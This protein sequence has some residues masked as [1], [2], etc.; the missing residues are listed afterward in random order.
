MNLVLTKYSSDTPVPLSVLPTIP[1]YRKP[2]ADRSSPDEIN[3]FRPANEIKGFVEISDNLCPAGYKLE[4]HE[5]NKKA[6]IY[7]MEKNSLN[8]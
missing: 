3:A 8:A 4:I 7:K 1:S 2:P 6:I 5:E